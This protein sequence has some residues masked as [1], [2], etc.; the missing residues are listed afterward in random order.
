MD[1]QDVSGSGALVQLVDV[2]RDHHQRSALSAETRLAL[3]DGSVSGAGLGVQGQLSAIVVEL[4]HAAGVTR[5]TLW[6]G[7]ILTRQTKIKIRNFH[8]HN[9]AKSDSRDFTTL[10]IH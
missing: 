10:Q 9:F 6:R 7:Q 3:G 5:E 1:L 4:P 2:L 8:I